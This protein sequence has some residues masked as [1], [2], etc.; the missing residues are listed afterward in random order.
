[1][2]A[3]VVSVLALL[4]ILY[5]PKMCKPRSLLLIDLQGGSEGLESLLECGSCSLSPPLPSMCSLFFHTKHLTC[6]LKKNK[7]GIVDLANNFIILS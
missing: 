2:R 3:A 6:F 4:P 7:I 1:M 5:S